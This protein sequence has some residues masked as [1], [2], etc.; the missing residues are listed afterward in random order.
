MAAA[1]AATG[2]GKSRAILKK[3]AAG[4]PYQENVNTWE[5]PERS[6]G[7][8]GGGR[9]GAS[10]L[11][12]SGLRAKF[13]LIGPSGVLELAHTGSHGELLNIQGFYESHW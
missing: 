7:G 6:G 3:Q 5:F 13:I 4:Y 9:V 11:M 2:I 1:S 10:V 8:E 12:V